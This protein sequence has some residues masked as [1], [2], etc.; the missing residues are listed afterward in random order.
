MDIIEL[1]VRES[2]TAYVQCQ[3]DTWFSS[4]SPHSGY[5]TL[6]MGVIIAYNPGINLILDNPVNSNRSSFLREREF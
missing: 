1:L 2:T 4:V 3:P 6:N 5:W